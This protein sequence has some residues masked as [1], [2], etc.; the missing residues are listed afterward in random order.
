MGLMI[1]LSKFLCCRVHA[2]CLTKWHRSQ[3]LPSATA[4]SL[5]T[6]PSPDKCRGVGKWNDV[7][8]TSW[9]QG[10]HRR[11]RG[12]SRQATLGR[13]R[14]NFDLKVEK[15][16]KFRTVGGEFWGRGELG[17]FEEQKEACVAGG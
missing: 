17:V 15:E 7:R 14:L 2:Q 8:T 11:C 3:V 10:G 5:K 1:C 16:S 12:S 4:S 13:G 6:T 9:R